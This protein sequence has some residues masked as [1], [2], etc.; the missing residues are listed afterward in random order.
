MLY[1]GFFIVCRHVRAVVLFNLVLYFTRIKICTEKLQ[2]ITAKL[3]TYRIRTQVEYMFFFWNSKHNNKS[4][5]GHSGIHGNEFVDSL[6]RTI[7]LLLC[8]SF[9]LLPWTDFYPVLKIHSYTLR[10]FYWSS[11]PTNSSGWYTFYC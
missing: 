9:N 8:P 11:F 3:C 5:S 7:S 1:W 4:L 2:N 6:A 10:S